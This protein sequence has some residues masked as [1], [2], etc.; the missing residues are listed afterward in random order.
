MKALNVIGG[1]LVFM[2]C[3]AFLDVG[4]F[5]GAILYQDHLV[6]SGSRIPAIATKVGEKQIDTSDGPTT[7]DLLRFTTRTGQVVT[8]TPN[9]ICDSS[10]GTSRTFPVL[11]DPITPTSID[12]QCTPPVP[13][14]ITAIGVGLIVPGIL[15]LLI[16]RFNARRP[17][18]KYSV[19]R[20]PRRIKRDGP[21]EE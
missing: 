17:K 1:L 13:I 9:T 12:E 3:V 19:P 16:A 10:F 18:E 14:G 11:Y 5:Y 21:P 2:G 4:I 6:A 8:A 7:T 15:L 20:R